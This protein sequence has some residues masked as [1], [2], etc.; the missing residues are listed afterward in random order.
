[1]RLHVL[2]SLTTSELL[3]VI[4]THDNDSLQALLK[5]IQGIIKTRNKKAA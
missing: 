5:G 1:M 2:A 3:D 4:A